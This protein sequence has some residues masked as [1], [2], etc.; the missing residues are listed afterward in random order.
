M[1]RKHYDLIVSLI[2]QHRKYSE[3]E[4]IIEDIINDIYQRA[5]YVLSTVNDE[6]VLKNYLSK[7]VGIS[8]ATISKKI[9]KRES[10]I[11]LPVDMEKRDD[12]KPVL[13]EETL[14]ENSKEELQE[15]NELIESVNFKEESLLEDPE[16]EFNEYMD[17]SLIDFE[18]EDSVSN[19]SNEEVLEKSNNY[20]S[21]DDELSIVNNSSI[22]NMEEEVLSIVED[23]D[24]SL[25][26]K[27]ING[28]SFVEQEM[29]DSEQEEILENNIEVIVEESDQSMDL[30]EVD[31]SNEIDNILDIV[32]EN[33]DTEDNFEFIEE[34]NVEQADSTLEILESVELEE[35]NEFLEA[36]DQEEV[37]EEIQENHELNGLEEQKTFES[38]N[39]YFESEVK[40]QEY[41]KE[42][43]YSE[44]LDFEK[45]NP[46]RRILEICDMKYNKKL[47]IE[48]IAKNMNITKEEVVSIL[49]EIIDKIKD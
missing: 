47:S 26:D 12:I 4:S 28:V 49:F 34:L 20:D 19:L 48:D 44:L 25:V 21:G 17:E 22:E 39:E 9:N 3:C 13:L 31:S 29:N 41:D 33:L 5:D 1:D 35:K 37:L 36:F 14:L 8:I 2:Q 18:Q 7:L 15:S 30:V 23:V 43:I 32:D 38:Y 45:Q 6:E 11:V 46:S 27:M 42:F 10:K 40:E 24:I 16:S